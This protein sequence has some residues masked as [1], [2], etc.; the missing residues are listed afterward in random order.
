MNVQQINEQPFCDNSKYRVSQ[1]DKTISFAMHKVW[2]SICKE[3][4][5][6]AACRNARHELQHL[7]FKIKKGT[8]KQ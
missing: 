4:H 6:F 2:E 3:S 1:S 8:L 7:V 5:N